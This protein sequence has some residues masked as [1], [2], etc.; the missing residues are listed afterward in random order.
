MSMKSNP[1][2]GPQAGFSLV[3]LLVAMVIT[4]IVSGAIYG[5]IASGEAAFRRDP[6]ITDRQ[7]NVRV[8]MSVI[9]SDLTLA[10]AGLMGTSQ[11]FTGGLTDFSGINNPKPAGET[12]PYGDALEIWSINGTCPSVPIKTAAPLAFIT[13][14]ALP[15]SC[16]TDTSY[17][18]INYENPN[19][20]NNQQSKTAIM[21]GL[22]TGVPKLE[23]NNPMVQLTVA[24]DLPCFGGAAACSPAGSDNTFPGS[25]N[26]LNVVRYEVAADPTDGVPSLFRSLTGGMDAAGTYAAPPAAA[27]NWQIVARGIA[28]LQVTYLPAGPPPAPAVDAWPTDPGVVS[29][30]PNTIVRE[31][32]VRLTGRT[33]NVSHGQSTEQLT[34]QL[35]SVTAPRAA[36]FQMNQANANLWN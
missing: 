29:P 2:K 8:A 32:R 26:L 20:L 14:P 18:L 16:Y 10:G 13:P 9:Q 15:P 30:D 28:N 11:I 31:V 1:T 21:S 4:L 23:T 35:T 34:A 24:A 27:G 5:L 25:I 17:V 7:Q 6:E 36:L 3:E 33:V 19:N 22:Q 12:A